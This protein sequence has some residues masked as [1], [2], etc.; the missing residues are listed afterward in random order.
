MLQ[1][2]QRLDHGGKGGSF[3]RRK[4]LDPSTATLK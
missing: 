1:L 2:L 4:L 3:K